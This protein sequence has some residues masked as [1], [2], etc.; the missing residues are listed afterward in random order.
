MFRVG[1]V[2]WPVG[3]LWCAILRQDRHQRARN[4][5]C[6]LMQR[7][8]QWRGQPVG[9]TSRPSRS[10]VPDHS[11]DVTRQGL[12]VD[13]EPD[14]LASTYP[15]T[16]KT[17]APFQLRVRT[18]YPRTQPVPLAPLPLG[19]GP[20]PTSDVHPGQVR[21]QHVGSTQ[22]PLSPQAQGRRRHLTGH[23]GRSVQGSH[24]SRAKCI[25]TRSGASSS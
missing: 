3:S 24:T 11:L 14:P 1:L 22:R 19:L 21:T 13:S 10:A 7:W 20:P 5:S 6:S 16:D 12:E 15:K 18:L 9:P 25:S 4:G 23:R 17:M 8:E 2:F